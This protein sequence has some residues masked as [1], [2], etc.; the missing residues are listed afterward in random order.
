MENFIARENVRWLKQQLEDCAG[1]AKTEQLQQL[2][3]GA[4]AELNASSRR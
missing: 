2:L 3:A 1:K 4:E